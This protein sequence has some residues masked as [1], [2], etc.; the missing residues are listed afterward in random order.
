M[1][2]GGNDAEVLARLAWLRDELGPALGRALRRAAALPLKSA[3]RARPDD[4]RR[5]A[6]A[7]R[8]LH[9]AC[10]CATLAPHSRAAHG[11]ALERVLDFIGG[12]DQF[13][14]NVAMAMGKSITRS[15]ARHRRLH[16]RHGDGRNGT[17]FG[18]RVAGTGRP[19]VH[20]AGRDAAGPLLPRLQRG[21]RQSRHGR[22][23]DRRS[24]RPGRL[25]DGGGA[26]G[27][28]LR[29]RR[30]ASRARSATRARWARSPSARNPHWHDPGA[31]VRRRADRHRHP[32]RGRDAA[33]RP[34]ST[35]ASRT[36]APGVGQVGA[37]VARAPLAC[38]EQALDC[39]CRCSLTASSA[40]ATSTRWR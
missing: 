1:R 13:F 31:R 32:P 8:R 16:H 6:P 17:D 5:D 25:R 3:H 29:R 40:G 38:F 2:F 10:C 23:R 12:N 28:R 9:L 26:R 14:L 15:G 27:G 22:L 7:Q 24:D 39:L 11:Q 33:S 36:S 20:R 34:P 21:R 4:G 19:L 18:I 30:A 35:P 37:G